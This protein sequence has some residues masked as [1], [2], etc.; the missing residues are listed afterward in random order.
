M[1][2][3]LFY[4]EQTVSHQQLNTST[5][6][7]LRGSGTYSSTNLPKEAGTGLDRKLHL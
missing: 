3:T 7:L 5:P 1:L 2:G 6:G 4:N